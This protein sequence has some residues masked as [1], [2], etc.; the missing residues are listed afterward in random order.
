VITRRL[1]A[2]IAPDK[3]A[4]STAATECGRSAQW[5]LAL[6]FTAG[7]EN[8]RCSFDAVE[9]IPSAGRGRAAQFV[10]IRFVF[11]NKLTR[12]DKL[13]LC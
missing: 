8:L 7:S 5:Q 1:V 9:R 12:H 4:T 10:P 6:D 13:L 2:G 3:C 11:S